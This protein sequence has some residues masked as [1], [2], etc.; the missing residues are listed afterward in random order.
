MST[1]KLEC[2]NVARGVISGKRGMGKESIISSGGIIGRC[3]G[4]WEGCK[5]VFSCTME[6]VVKEEAAS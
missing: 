4:R 2:V 1:G 6:S 3:W 5:T